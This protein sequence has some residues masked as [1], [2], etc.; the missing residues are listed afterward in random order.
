MPTPST[1]RTKVIDVDYDQTEMPAA[2]DKGRAYPPRVLQRW[3]ETLSRNIPVRQVSRILDL[4]CGTGRYSAALA[5]HFCCQ[6]EAIDPSDRMLEQARRKP[7]AGVRFQK[8]SGEALP[9]SNESVDL[10]FMSMVFHHFH[11]PETVAREC[12][13]VLR[14]GGIVCLRAGTREQIPTYPYV[15]F[16]PGSVSILHAVLQSREFIE[17]AFVRAKIGYEHHEL[18][19]NEVASSWEEYAIKLSHRADSVLV[20]L[21]DEEFYL[22]LESVRRYATGRAQANPVI[23]LVDFFVFRLNQGL[24]SLP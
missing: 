10:V 24:S 13:R 5:E 23:E 21:S 16:F 14:P 4:G 19:E 6:V 3:L 17:S 20:Q 1:E 12:R 11:D 18:V 8:A 9:L 7:H 15:R 2:Y 22:G